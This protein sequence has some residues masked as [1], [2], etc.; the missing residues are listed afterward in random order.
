MVPESGPLLPPGHSRGEWVCVCKEM[1][2]SQNPEKV[3]KQRA[4]PAISD[5]TCL[6]KKK[7]HA[8]AGAVPTKV[9]ACWRR[10]RSP[11]PQRKKGRRK[12]T[13]RALREAFHLHL[14]PNSFQ[15]VGDSWRTSLPHRPFPA[16]SFP[17][18]SRPP[19]PLA[20]PMLFSE[21]PRHLSKITLQAAF[22]SASSPSSSSLPLDPG[23]LPPP[24]NQMLPHP[25]F[26]SLPHPCAGESLPGKPQHPSARSLPSPARPG[27][28]KGAGGG[29]R[30]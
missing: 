28:L 3:W 4:S 24:P 10:L 22:P 5:S 16:P 29:A 13:G 7:T 30:A 23:S 26:S 20:A 14:H 2:S 21:P 9:R 8:T 19:G 1:P 17:S 12:A 27:F 18:H 6:S 11:G 25:P 15:V